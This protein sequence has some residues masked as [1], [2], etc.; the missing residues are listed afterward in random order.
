M[1]MSSGMTWVVYER[2][3]LVRCTMYGKYF[4]LQRFTNVSTAAQVLSFQIKS[5]NNKGSVHL[6][7]Y[8]LYSVSSEGTVV[9]YVLDKSHLPRSYVNNSVERSIHTYTVSTE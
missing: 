2:T 3:M 5:H 6:F 7:F 1:Q 9:N 4:Y 8:C